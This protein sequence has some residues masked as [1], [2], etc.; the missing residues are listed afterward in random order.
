MV[1]LLATVTI[2]GILATIATVSVTRTM[3]KA[4]KEYDQK[5]NKLFT[6]AAQ[7]Y[8]TDNRNALPKKLLT[9]SEVT[10]QELID[11]NYIEEIVD[12][13][14]KVYDKEKSKA[15]VKKTGAGK[16]I[17][18]SVL[19]GSDG[20]QIKDNLENKKSDDIETVIGAP[21][22]T[23]TDMKKEPFTESDKTIYYVNKQITIP[24]KLSSTIGISSY[25]YKIN[26]LS[27]ITATGKKYKTSGEIAIDNTSF[28]DTISI[29]AKDFANGIYQ[30]E[31]DAYGYQAERK[32]QKAEYIIVIDKTKPKCT[33]SVDGTPGNFDKDIGATWFKAGKLTAKMTITEQNKYMYT[34]GFNNM[35]NNIIYEKNNKKE[36]EEYL[37]S[38]N[39]KNK[40]VY[41]YVID[42]AG[43]EG[44][45]ET[46]K[47]IYYDNTIPTCEITAKEPDGNNGWYLS[48][49]S[50]SLKRY[51]DNRQNQSEQ[52]D[53]ESGITAYGL[54]NNSTSNYNSKYSDTIDVEGANIIR[55]GYVKD[56]A[57]NEGK[58]EKTFK[59]ETNNP[60][61]QVN[62]NKEQSKINNSYT[63]WFTEDV[64]A[65]V[66]YE[67]E[68]ISG[69]SRTHVKYGDR[70]T[71]SDPNNI[72]LN[73][74]TDD[75][76]YGELVDNAGRWAT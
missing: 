50:L 36:E 76:V 17:Y 75:W 49:I 54:S 66:G 21:D 73:N 41:G 4:H 16:Y 29:N 62:F 18:Y 60:T 34:L 23:Y 67:T 55:Y 46:E 52:G 44:N 59:L 40:K 51:D 39:I 64:S 42:K 27:S 56:K 6:T 25:Q 53:N 35:Q 3:Q 5:Q 11:K 65:T 2:L 14:K 15:Y 58:C 10:L 8:F 28:S 69:I 47:P 20:R 32:K 68:T 9:T 30:L 74:G 72:T 33:I 13:K 12:Y 37:I 7:K 57:G 48:A 38:Q 70:P 61:C 26:K 31:I 19:V 43:N 22:L 24:I 63:G 1:E 45:C 71:S